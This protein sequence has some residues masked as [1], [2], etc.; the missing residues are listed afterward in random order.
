[1]NME[2]ADVN[3]FE[4]KGDFDYYHLA[5]D[6]FTKR[7]F[8]RECIVDRSKKPNPRPYIMVSDISK[9]VTGSADGRVWKPI[10]GN[11][12][13]AAAMPINFSSDFEDEMFPLLVPI[14]VKET[15][16][17][18]APGLFICKFPNDIVCREHKRKV[19]GVLIRK[20]DGFV[21]IFLGGNLVAAPGIDELRKDSYG[22]CCMKNHIDKV[23][24]PYEFAVEFYRNVLALKGKYN[25]IEKV[26]EAQNTMMNEYLPN[27]KLSINNPNADLKK[28]GAFWTEDFPNAY[29]KV[30]HDGKRYQYFSCYYDNVFYKLE[31]DAE[32]PKHYHLTHQYV[33]DPKK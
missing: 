13:M 14:A 16:D 15:Y 21:V 4:N 30:E 22:A 11:L 32:K 17:H 8:F 9:N 2:N 20:M 25:T 26:L 12:H 23:P 3:N 28:D 24:T 27:Y 5:E 6:D 29:L 7:L 33:D 31:G 18:Y 10:L 1:M 19:S